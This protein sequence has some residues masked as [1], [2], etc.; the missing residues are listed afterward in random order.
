[1]AQRLLI[2]AVY[3]EETR[4]VSVDDGKIIGF[5]FES[6]ARKQGV[7]SIYLARV[8]R[9]EAALQAV[10]LEYGGNRHGFLAFPEI[11]PDYYHIP[12]ADQTHNR[13][14]Q[15]E[16][17]IQSAD[18]VD[19]DESK[20]ETE[21]GDAKSKP[22]D[23]DQNSPETPDL[24]EAPEK[25][26]GES[27]STAD[28]SST[29]SAAK[30]QRNRQK[31]RKNRASQRSYRI[32]EVIRQNQ[33]LLVQV[34]KEERGNKGA[35]LTT[36]ISLA[37]RYCVLMPN[38]NR[39][40]GISKKITNEADRRKLKDIASDIEV[41]A[42]VGLI[43]R[44][45]GANRTKQEIRRDY[46][47]LIRQWNEIRALTLNSI[48]PAKIYEEGSL[49]RRAIRDDYLKGMDAVMVQGSDG[50]R[51]A[52]D[53]M[54]MIMPSHA[55]KVKQ[56][57]GPEPI[58]THYGVEQQLSGLLRPTAALPSGGHIV[59]AVTEA[60]ISIDVNSGK[61]TQHGTLEQT[62]LQTNLE[63]AEVIADQL[64]LRD[65]GGLIV[66]DFID[67]EESK[68]NATV[69]K[70]FRDCTKDDRARIQFGRITNFGLLEMSRQRLK[71]D[72][73]EMATENCPYCEGL[74]YQRTDEVLA[75][76]VLRRIEVEAA[77]GEDQ[78]IEALVPYKIANFLLNKKRSAIINI[79]AKHKVSVFVEGAAVLR[80]QDLEIRRKRTVKDSSGEESENVI[81]IETPFRLGRLEHE[82]SDK[83]SEPPRKRRRRVSRGNANRRL[84]ETKQSG[85]KNQTHERNEE[86]AAHSQNDSPEANP[87]SSK[88]KRR[89][90][91]RSRKKSTSADLQEGNA[92]IP[93]KSNAKT[94]ADNATPSTGKSRPSTNRA[95]K[96]SDERTDSQDAPQPAVK[97]EEA[98][99]SVE[100]NADPRA[101]SDSTKTSPAPAS[102]NNAED[103]ASPKRV[104]WWSDNYQQEN[105]SEIQ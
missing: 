82:Q 35:A 92:A 38:S 83:R 21:T 45:A 65:L 70:R 13:R 99:R 63:A 74:G 7:G 37:G 59:I 31:P 86:T 49:V 26:A 48:A 58:F 54:K 11:H 75:I 22:L 27:Q 8:V 77:K 98:S 94:S 53:F 87:D 89:N 105:T 14:G 47:F 4:V 104:G 78:T 85:K 33:I 50:Y 96:R 51:A 88:P 17:G 39:G 80:E 43:I 81:D 93:E 57:T 6:T 29:E 44:T 56:H 73:M 68:N 66:I 20:L 9:I 60:L 28:N 19:S 40:G 72:I 76:D 103:E 61:A 46:E 3:P 52:K 55:K 69:L 67:M 1:M 10:F 23:A 79:E 36:Y 101:S 42:D 90:R 71:T 15:N 34:T 30:K 64:K 100:S 62:A 32:Q 95:K 97:I 12:V 102:E 91:R 24:L 25:M 16:Q 84:N 18:R 5:E 2:D 41:P